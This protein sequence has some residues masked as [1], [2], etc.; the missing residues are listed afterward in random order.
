MQAVEPSYQ[1]L[2]AGALVAS[3][4]TLTNILGPINLRSYPHKAFAVVNHG[5][6]TLSGVVVQVNPDKHGMQQ[7]TALS[8]GA[9]PVPNPGLW[10]NL[11]TTTFQSLAS[12]AC[13]V[14]SFADQPYPWWRLV[15]VNYQ[16]PAVSISGWA[17]AQ[18]I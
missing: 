4:S 2:D 7:G 18:T 17:M 8:T 1:H 15:A 11:D 16:P 5:T 12:G 10:V 3:G 14:V 6:V 13:K 9:T